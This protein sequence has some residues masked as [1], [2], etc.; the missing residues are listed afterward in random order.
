MPLVICGDLNVAP[1]EYDVWNHK[2][3]VEDRQPHPDRGRGDGQAQGQRRL[4]R[5]AARSDAGTRRSWPHRWSYRAAD[6][7]KP[8][9]EACASTTS[10]SPPA[11]AKRPIAWARSRP[12]CMT[13]CGGWERPS[14]PCADHGRLGVVAFGGSAPPPSLVSNSSA[15]AKARLARAPTLQSLSS[16]VDHPRHGGFHAKAAGSA[17]LRSAKPA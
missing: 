6:F 2:S 7:R 10:G 8:P 13:T 4:H 11:C 1:G 9:T 17:Q 14:G 16:T 12:A 15:L 3:H 5:P